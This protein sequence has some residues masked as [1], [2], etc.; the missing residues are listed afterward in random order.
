MNVL[1][2]PS[3]FPTRRET[4][5]GNFIYEYARSLTL[6][7][8]VTVVYPQQLGNPGVGKEPFFID[9]LLESRIRLVNYTYPHLSKTWMLSY[10]AAFHRILRRI[11]REWQI[12]II[13]AQ[14]AL[15][16]GLGALMLRRL[17]HIPVILTEHWGPPEEWLKES[18]AP[19]K[20]VRAVVANTYRRV[21]YLTAVSESL[22]N[23]IGEVFGAS[24]DGKLDQP[25]D[26]DVFYPTD[27]KVTSAQRRVLCVTRG[28][29][30]PRKGVS[31]LID[32]WKIVS[33]R[34]RGSANLSI[35]GPNIEELTSQINNAGIAE[36][37]R[38]VS[39]KP[40]AE[41]AALMRSSSLV[42]IPSS[43]ETF[44]RSGAEALACGVPVISTRCGGPE[45][46][47]G[48]GTGLLVPSEDPNA[49][50]EGIMAGLERRSD[51][52]SPEDLA[53]RIRER[54]GYEAVCRRFTEIATELT[55]RS[56]RN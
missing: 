19:R 48:E 56:S 42:V 28:K 43:Y 31:N 47:M 55:K 46:Y 10:L 3:S 45:E 41:L 22:A 6:Q 8:Q 4:W 35:A 52:L 26:C 33:R 30:D 54:F 51:F 14:V 11:R 50:A 23:Q 15:P 49:L 29:F 44:G 40:A 25:I 21:D 27:G 34:T 37:C 36:S 18:S 32:A 24:V 17:F 16:A 38:L 9:E 7:H 2:I 53:R 39:W 5:H 13:F 12:D 1:L 20:L